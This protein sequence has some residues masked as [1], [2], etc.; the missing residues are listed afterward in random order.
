MNTQFF[1]QI[2]IILVFGIICSVQDIKSMKVRNVVIFSGCFVQLVFLAVTD[3]HTLW[4]PLCCGATTGLFYFAVRYI[5]HKKLGMAD[6][7]FGIFQGLCLTPIVMCIC[8]LVEC[9]LALAAFGFQ[10]IR[11]SK[12]DAVAFIPFMAI[13]LLATA[14]YRNAITTFIESCF[15]FFVGL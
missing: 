10:K 13:S 9:I 7:Y 12:N 3:L 8:I 6:V 14:A 11:K 4:M 5:T 1:L 2:I 15:E